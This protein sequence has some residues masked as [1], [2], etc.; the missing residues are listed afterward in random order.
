MNMCVYVHASM[1]EGGNVCEHVCMCSCIDERG[2]EC[3]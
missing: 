3:V 1:R 2:R